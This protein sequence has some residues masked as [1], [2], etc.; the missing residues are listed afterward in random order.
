MVPYSRSISLGH[1]CEV[2]WQINRHFDN[3]RDSF[4]NWL[5][6]PFESVTACLARRFVAFAALE[7][8]AVVDLPNARTNLMFYQDTVV[9]TRYR[10]DLHHDFKRND[11]HIDRESIPHLATSVQTSYLKR[12]QQFMEDLQCE[13]AVL[14]IRRYGNFDVLNT[15]DRSGLTRKQLDE[16]HELVHSVNPRLDYDLLLLNME[17]AVPALRSN[18][19]IDRV[20][21]LPTHLPR[22]VQWKGCS[23]DWDAVI[24]RTAAWREARS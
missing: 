19:R 18:E 14:F 4:F 22:S 8:L 15:Q 10:V 13:G 17:G 5:I 12:G 3:R 20:R 6:T 1:R 23:E 16:F 21:N 2:A 7:H 9:E 11:R 24:S